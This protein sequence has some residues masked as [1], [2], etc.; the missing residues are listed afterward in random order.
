M[1]I[2]TSTVKRA[3]AMVGINLNEITQNATPLI[4]NEL[5]QRLQDITLLPGERAGFTLYKN[6]DK[7]YIRKVAIAPEGS[8]R[9]L[10]PAQ[11]LDSTIQTIINTLL[12]AS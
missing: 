8:L 1:N 10:E 11:H 6:G 9:P 12:H 7:Y 4:I 5:D 2:S 3:L